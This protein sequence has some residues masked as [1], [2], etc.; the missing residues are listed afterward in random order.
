[1]PT[2][3]IAFVVEPLVAH[4]AEGVKIR[5][6][7]GSERLAILDPFMLLDHL[8]LEAPTDGRV[9]FPRHPHR[10]IE[11]L[12]YVIDG[13]VF[14]KDSLG[15]EDSV[16]Q[17]EAQWMTA[18][19]GIWHEEMLEAVD[20]KVEMLQLWFALPKADKMIAPGYAAGRQLTVID[21]D[22]THVRDVSGAFSTIT[23]DPYIA[24]VDLNESEFACE[25]QNLATTAFY[26]FRGS[27]SVEGREVEA[28]NLAVLGSGDEVRVIG[29][30]RLLFISAM[31]LMEPILQ[32]RSFV[33]NHPDDIR[34]VEEDIKSGRFG[35]E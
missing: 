3:E 19:R 35:L 7:I 6:T 27:V 2:R 23:G 5:R 4:E 26:V 31:P 11:T 34:V 18:G 13:R 8:T 17:D 16:G 9:G 28:G 24:Q 14:H 22:G 25:V 10:G 1:M 33:M 30:G 29:S 32:Y 21:E 20:G 15:N 12:S